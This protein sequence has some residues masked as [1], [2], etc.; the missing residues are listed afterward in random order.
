MIFAI[1]EDD[2]VAEGFAGRVEFFAY[3]QGMHGGLDLDQ[4]RL[5]VMLEW[6]LIPL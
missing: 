5:A 3:W 4:Y 6:R 1:T 2:A